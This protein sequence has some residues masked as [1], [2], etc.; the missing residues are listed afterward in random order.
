MVSDQYRCIFIEVPKTGSTSIRSIVGNPLKPHQNIWQVFNSVNSDTFRAYFKF[1]FVRNP[2]D[3]AV[4]L[5]ERK[6]GLQLKSRM[7]FEQFVEWMQ[8]ASCTCIHPVPHRYQLDWFLSPHGDL[9]LDFIGR[10]ERLDADWAMVAARLGIGNTPLPRLNVNA[11]RARD[12]TAY[13]TPRTRQIIAE[14][15]AI[16]VEYFG[17]KF[18]E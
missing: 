14:R 11:E 9:L 18:G 12:Y 17:Y 8:L 6:E 10:Y 16:D 13:Y 5:Y 2:W 1:G 7:N 4:S 3:R 15:F